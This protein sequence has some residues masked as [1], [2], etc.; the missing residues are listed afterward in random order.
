[1]KCVWLRVF[2]AKRFPLTA[3]GALKCEGLETKHADAVPRESWVVLPVYLGAGPRS[4]WAIVRGK[5]SLALR[6]GLQEVRQC[7]IVRA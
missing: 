2:D 7:R 4:R 6:K 5:G 3:C 1:M